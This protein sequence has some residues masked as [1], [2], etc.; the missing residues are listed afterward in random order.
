MLLLFFKSRN[1][2]DTNYSSGGGGNKGFYGKSKIVDYALQ[3]RRTK[4]LRDNLAKKLGFTKPEKATPKAV[5]ERIEILEEGLES[6]E[7]LYID[8]PMP[9]IPKDEKSLSEL[10]MEL[11]EQLEIYRHNQLI[12]LILLDED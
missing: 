4:E 12:L 2:G 5:E 6:P 8:L 7:P 11:R 9:D 3:N 1:A 10:I